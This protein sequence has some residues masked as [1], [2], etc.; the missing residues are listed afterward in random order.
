MIYLQ[1]VRTPRL[2]AIHVLVAL[3]LVVSGAS[4][5]DAA[6]GSSGVTLTSRSTLVLVPA[7]VKTRSGELVY[8]LT[9]KDFTLTDDGVPQTLRLEEDSGSEPLALV[10]AVEIG[11]GGT[12]HLEQYKYLSP[13]LDALLGNIEHRIAVVTFDSSP[14]LAQKFTNSTD[15]AAATLDNLEPGDHQAA[16][17][18]AIA[19]SVDLLRTQPAG[20]R[21]A[22]LLLSETV[23][24]ASHTT[25]GQ[26]LRALGDTNTSIYSVGFASTKADIARE[27]AKL[28]SDEP[29]P[30][31]GCFAHDPTA[32]NRAT[33]NFDCLAQLLPPLRLAK[34]AEIAA[35]DGLRRNVPETVARLTGGEYFKFKDAKTL[36]HDLLTIANHIPNRY[37]LSFQPRAP[38][39]GMHALELILKDYDHL[40]IEARRSY[41]VDDPSQ[42]ASAPQK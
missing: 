34:M 20:Y 38:H 18:D 31:H 7:L 10:I 37:V 16:T 28:N 24:A 36:N 12:Q 6:P 9:V 13:M 1:T 29:G 3:L 41:W 21:R 40:T 32:D 22:I 19:Y 25:L 5:Q 11:A 27:G 2:D 14:I 23:D 35:R 42:P 39:P 30:E 26:A 15:E 17:L 4:A 8:A 33:Q